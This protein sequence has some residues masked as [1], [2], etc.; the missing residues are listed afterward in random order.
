MTRISK[1]LRSDR[2]HC[3]FSAILDVFAMEYLRDPNVNEL[4]DM[5]R[6][7]GD[8]GVIWKL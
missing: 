2:L 5:I 3:T 4:N 1:R 7:L 8:N 6:F